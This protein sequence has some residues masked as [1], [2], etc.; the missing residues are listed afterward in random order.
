M[1]VGILWTTEIHVVRR[2][3]L[4]GLTMRRTEGAVSLTRAH[5]AS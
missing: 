4:A 2:T 5:E 1:D 3:E